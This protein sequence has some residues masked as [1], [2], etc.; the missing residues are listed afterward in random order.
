MREV[1]GVTDQQ[2][3]AMRALEA[4]ETWLDV[5]HTTPREERASREYRF[6]GARLR[7]VEAPTPVVQGGDSP[8]P[9]EAAARALQDALPHSRTTVMPG[10]RHTA[11][12]TATELFISE[13]V[14]FLAVHPAE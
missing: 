2:L 5:A 10:Q 3:E 8:A 12:D 7:G 14:G 1:A 13:V 9:F 4:W 11:M 6:D